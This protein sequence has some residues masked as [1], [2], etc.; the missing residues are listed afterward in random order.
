MTVPQYNIIGRMHSGETVI[1]WYEFAQS[2][3][4][5][6]VALRNGHSRSLH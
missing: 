5:N 1:L 4:A 6:Q 3:S 2:G